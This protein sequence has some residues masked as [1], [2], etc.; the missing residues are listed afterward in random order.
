MPGL[1][2]FISDPWAFPALSIPQI[3][4]RSCTEILSVEPSSVC[5]NGER[6]LGHRGTLRKVELGPA[7]ERHPV[8]SAFL[9]TFQRPLT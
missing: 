6:R 1:D 5:V 4:K 2:V 7:H 8:L 9:F 3:L